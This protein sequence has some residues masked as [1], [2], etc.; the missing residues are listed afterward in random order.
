MTCAMKNLMGIVWDREAFHRQNLD[1]CIAD[2]CLF[3]K[4]ALNV[5]DAWKVMLSGGPRGYAGSRYDEQRMLMLST[6]LVAADAASAKVL[7]KSKEDFGYIAKAEAVG[8]G[9]ADLAALNIL[10]L[11][12]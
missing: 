1:Q 7:G 5:V 8:I 3:R 12:M 2:S 6:D 9:R 4:P 10:R 11:T